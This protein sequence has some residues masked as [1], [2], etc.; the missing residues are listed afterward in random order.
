MKIAR[1]LF[2]LVVVMLFLC[3]PIISHSGGTDSKGGHRNSATGE[4]HYHHGHSAHQ[5]TDL[6]GDGV[7]DCPYDFV[8]KTRQSSGN[9]SSSSTTSKPTTP[10]LTH[11]GP[12][13]SNGSKSS[14]TNE[15]LS[16]IL[17]SSV[18][19]PLFSIF[20]FAFVIWICYVMIKHDLKKKRRRRWY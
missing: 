14:V 7:K 6:D 13:V 16:T 12:R 20:A 11:T 19:F 18:L 2:L 17:I 8:N 3:L 1:V 9:S 15:N 10:D 4:Y 5:H